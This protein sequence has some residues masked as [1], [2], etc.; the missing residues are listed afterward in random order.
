M[1]HEDEEQKKPLDRKAYYREYHREHRAPGGDQY[2]LN[3]E[4]NKSEQY[5]V[6][7]RKRDNARY[8]REREKLLAK[9]KNRQEETITW[10]RQYKATITCMRCGENNPACLQ[11]HHRNRAEK[12]RNIAEYATHAGSIEKLI[13]EINKCDVLCANCHSIEHWQEKENVLSIFE[14]QHAIQGLLQGGGKLSGL[15]RG[16]MK[17][18][19]AKLEFESFKRTLS[20]QNC[21]VNHPACLEFHHRDRSEKTNAVS[22]LVRR[23]AQP[24]QLKR[25]IEKC[26]VLCANCH[27]KLH[28]KQN[29][30]K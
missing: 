16:R 13:H 24:E 21:G 25:E 23:Y 29:S 15:E 17:A 10:F 19:L 7:R 26:D 11:F 8:Q 30:Q 6:N 2:E 22:N 12:K 5:K 9:V 28:W 14:E 4:R 20:C 1:S 27:A 3:K 18:R